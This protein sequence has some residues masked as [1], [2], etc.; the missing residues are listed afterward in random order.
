[1]GE[2]QFG[3][4]YVVSL[5]IKVRLF[6]SLRCR[7]AHGDEQLRLPSTSTHTPKNPLKFRTQICKFFS[8]TGK[9]GN[10]NKCA[11]IHSGEPVS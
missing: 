4:K 7:Y 5:N 9:C 11:F 8:E 3:E 1:M 10:G 6:N 2:C